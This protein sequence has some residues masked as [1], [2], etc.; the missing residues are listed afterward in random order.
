MYWTSAYVR[1]SYV[2]SPL[3]AAYV[4]SRLICKACLCADHG[5]C[6]FDALMYRAVYVLRRLCTD[7]MCWTADVPSRL[8][9]E[10]AYVRT[11]YVLGRPMH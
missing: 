6:V 10:S 4:L 2:L 5:T 1:T 3:V 8:I 9:T 11:S 7:P